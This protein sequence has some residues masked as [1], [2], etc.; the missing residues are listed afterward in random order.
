MAIITSQV[1]V[2]TVPVI[3]TNVPPGPCQVIVTVSG[4]IG[5]NTVFL[6]TSTLVTTTSG[7]HIISGVPWVFSNYV[8]SRPATLYA[9]TSTSV[10]AGGTVGCGVAVITPELF[11]CA[12]LKDSTPMRIFNVY[13]CS[14]PSRLQ[15]Y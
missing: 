5:T 2:G 3:L 9:V 8:T 6:G 12:C 1:A 10:T 11:S 14:A 15:W 13:S 7:S 4:S